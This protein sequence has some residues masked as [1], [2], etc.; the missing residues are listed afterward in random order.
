MF[1]VSVGTKIMT[2]QGMSFNVAGKLKN[3]KILKKVQKLKEFVSN[4]LHY[5]QVILL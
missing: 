1:D 5:L 3:K 2:K 4:S